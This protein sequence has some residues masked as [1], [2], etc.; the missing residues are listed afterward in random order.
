[1]P[2]S[3]VRWRHYGETV[4]PHLPTVRIFELSVDKKLITRC[5]KASGVTQ[6]SGFSLSVI[7]PTTS[8]GEFERLSTL[9]MFSPCQNMLPSVNP[10]RVP[11]RKAAGGRVRLDGYVGAFLMVFPLFPKH[12]S[13]ALY[14]Y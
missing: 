3:H 11:P 13:K 9:S 8:F 10:M 6:S 5:F 1:M 4:Q 14:L 2:R 12:L 7:Q